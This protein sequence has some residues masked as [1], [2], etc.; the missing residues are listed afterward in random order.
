[1]LVKKIYY[2]LT[3][4]GPGTRTGIWTV[5]CFRNCFNCIAKDLQKPDSSYKMEVKD[6]VAEIIRLNNGKR[7]RM[8]VSGGEPLLQKDLLEFLKELR[9]IGADDILLYT[10]FEY[11]EIEKSEKYSPLLDYIDALID[12]PYIESLN[13]N[14]A[15]RG[16]SNQRIIFLNDKYKEEYLSYLLKPREIQVDPKESGF[17]LLGIV[18]KGFNEGFNRKM[19]KKGYKVNK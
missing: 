4:L 7:I 18:P 16:S 6:V 9:K 15:L 3:S 14:K 11:E 17:D 10:G 19:D 12:G 8:T 2:P 13:D 5:G 1:M